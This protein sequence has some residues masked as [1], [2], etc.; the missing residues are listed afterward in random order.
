MFREAY[1]FNKPLNNW[2]VSLAFYMNGMFQ[3][4]TAFNQNIGS[5]N[6]QN[7]LDFTNFMAGKTNLDYSATNLDAIY[8]GWSSFT[9]LAIGI[10]I[11]F[12]SIKYTL[13]GQTGKNILL[14]AP[15]NWL[16]T[17]GGI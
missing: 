14:G 9:P 2:N 16:I 13:A 5:W 3:L 17:D 11:N 4:A 1:A 10:N 6:I 8:N 12:N 7:V 15:N